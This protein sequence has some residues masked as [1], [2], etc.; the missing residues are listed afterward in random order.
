MSKIPFAIYTR[1][2]AQNGYSVPG[3]PAMP[4]LLDPAAN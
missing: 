1:K 2:R 4:D 3:E